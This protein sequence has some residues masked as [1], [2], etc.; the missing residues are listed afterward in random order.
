MNANKI[1]SKQHE[2]RRKKTN[3]QTIHRSIFQGEEEV[4]NNLNKYK[5]KSWLFHKASFS[6][7]K[8]ITG[9]SEGL[10]V[11]QC[12][13]LHLVLVSGINICSC[14]PRAVK[15]HYLKKKKSSLF[16]LLLC[17]TTKNTKPLV[18]SIWQ[19][20]QAFPQ[21]KLDSVAGLF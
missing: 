7:M 4:G 2:V 10:K 11:R 3:H 17:I 19:Q 8:F 5:H 1:L 14:H 12:I 16:T 9:P 15:C 13:L 20:N 18:E 21:N 6:Q